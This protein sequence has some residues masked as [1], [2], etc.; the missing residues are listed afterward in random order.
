V[1]VRKCLVHNGRDIL[2]WKN[3]LEIFLHPSILSFDTKQYECTEPT[4][5][6][7]GSIGSCVIN[8]ACIVRLCSKVRR[9]SPSQ[10]VDS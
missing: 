3:Y 4:S 7:T 2:K 5:Q 1:A 6:I 9:S 8:K 10:R